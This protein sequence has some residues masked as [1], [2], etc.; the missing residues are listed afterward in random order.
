[1][2]I[3]EWGTHRLPNDLCPSCWAG[4][5]LQSGSRA[6]CPSC[7][8]VFPYGWVRG[9]YSEVL[10]GSLTPGEGPLYASL[11]RYATHSDKGPHLMD[12]VLDLD[13][14]EF[15]QAV[16]AAQAY[17]E[18]LKGEPFTLFF[19]GSKGFHF[20]FLAETFGA[21][22]EEKPHLRLRHMAS[23]LQLEYPLDFS[24]YS[25]RR[26]LRVPNTRHPKTGLFKVPLAV[27]EI[28]YALDL[29]KA[30][31]PYTP[32][33]SPSKRLRELY[34]LPV[35]EEPV[36]PTAALEGFTP[37]CVQHLLATGPPMP[38]TR[39]YLTLQLAVFF[40]RSGRSKEELLEWARTTPGASATPE[41]ERVND[42]ARAYDWAVKSR[43]KLSCST[44]QAY[45]LCSTDC[46]LYKKA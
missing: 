42:A 25:T 1:M 18:H 35:P 45:G 6:V 40:A 19:S 7:G 36:T 24:V 12:F 17:A 30:P 4:R 16:R 9:I 41:R 46:P 10:P 28:P 11:Q 3:R 21:V 14:P 29:A 43:A 34:S 20:V 44:M 23:R 33:L 31:R 13:Y 39:H 2:N 22:P 38:G 37:P 27:E 5:L 15:S 26:L 8:E 32:N